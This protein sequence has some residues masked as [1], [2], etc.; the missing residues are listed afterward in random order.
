M[1]PDYDYDYEGDNSTYDEQLSSET[2]SLFYKT[3]NSLLLP[4]GRKKLFF[5]SSIENV[6][7]ADDTYEIFSRAAHA[8]GNP[9]GILSDVPHFQVFSLQGGDLNYNEY[10][11]SHSRQFRS[12]LM[13]ERIYWKSVIEKCGLRPEGI[14]KE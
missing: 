10:H 7:N 12:N 8:W 14:S 13:N 1:R 2:P 6:E 3:K 9:I 5:P 11:Y 4:I